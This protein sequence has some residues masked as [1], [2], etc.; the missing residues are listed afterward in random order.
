MPTRSQASMSMCRDSGMMTAMVG[1]ITTKSVSYRHSCVSSKP[2]L[3]Y[4]ES[5][6]W[7]ICMILD[8]CSTPSHPF[9]VIQFLG[10]ESVKGIVEK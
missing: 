7:R 8:L 4:S 10:S 6:R 2:P 5:N 9:R 3:E 1:D